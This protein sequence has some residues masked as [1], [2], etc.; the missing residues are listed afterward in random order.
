MDLQLTNRVALVTGSSRG[1]GYAIAKTLRAEGCRVFANSRQSA[2][3]ERLEG[4]EYVVGDVSD[5]AQ[6][7]K[8]MSEV[9]ERAGGLDILVCNVGSG[10][11]V[12]PGQETPE[13]WDRMLKQNFLASTNMAWAA[14]EA[15][16]QSKGN[17]V[18]ISSICGSEL[19][20][21]S[22]T[23]SASKSALNSFMK[24]LSKA[25]GPKGV[26]VNGVAPGNIIFEGSVWDRKMKDSP[27]EIQAL[28]DRDVP[29]ARLG[30]PDEIASVVAFLASPRSSFMT[31][32]LVTVDGGQTKAL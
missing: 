19:F 4:F 7:K 18:F 11:S 3:L 8:I 29:L 13:E 17:L 26:R 32:S 5:S 9:I 2:D 21:P 27:K 31:G 28:L 23:Y 22:L 14:Q 20:G 12:P 15:L 10:R 25:L 6:S 16:V 30:S 24:G 1:I